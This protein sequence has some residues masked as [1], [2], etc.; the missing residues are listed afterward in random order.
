MIDGKK[1]N[2][3]LE[4]GDGEETAATAE[5]IEDA[6]T[7]SLESDETPTPDDQDQDGDNGGDGDDV[8]A[9]DGD[10]PEPAEDNPDEPYDPVYEDS[11]HDGDAHD[12][13][14]HED[15][16][17]VEEHHEDAHHE[18]SQGWSFAA[19]AL[20]ALILLIIGAGAA[21]I[22]GPKLAPMLPAGVAAVLT[23][24]SGV[25]EEEMEARIAALESAFAAQLEAVQAEI[26][27]AVEQSAATDAELAAQIEETAAAG[28]NGDDA[29]LSGRVDEAEASIAGLRE[30]IRALSGQPAV[31]GGSLSDAAVSGLRA[32]LAALNDKAASAIDDRVA[33]LEE[34]VAALDQR[35]STAEESVSADAAVGKGAASAAAFAALSTTVT[36]AAPYANELE[37]FT[38][39]SGAEAPEVLTAAAGTGVASLTSL[40]ATFPDAANA[41]VSAATL[42]AAGEGYAD[43]ALAWVKSRV[44]IR[45]AEEEEGVT[46][47]A[48]LSRA[49]ARLNEGA[50]KAALAELDALP[51]VSREAM[52]S[53]L[54]R[55]ENRAA[56]DAALS[57][58]ATAMLPAAPASN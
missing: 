13:G 10:D 50:L 21:L 9:A 23:P 20:A 4:T 47:A 41:A 27:V 6:T 22:G 11:A 45:P 33:P 8:I 36:S 31:E 57:D 3:D 19:K 14:H 58:L 29:A 39:V 38:S 15:E 54:T 53:W 28:A 42:A 37:T 17:H 43:Q 49:E 25:N 16:H 55:A 56:V 48:V 40:T 2:D 12:D 30:E 52:G 46:P 34:Q 32:E 5:T 7:D 26:V 18:D 51:T 35:L 24:G 1:E 44:A